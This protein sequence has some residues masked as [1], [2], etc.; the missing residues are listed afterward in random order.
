MHTMYIIILNA[1]NY[2]SVLF[3][4]KIMFFSEIIRASEKPKVDA[5]PA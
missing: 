2:F 5:D 3:S 1:P 4:D